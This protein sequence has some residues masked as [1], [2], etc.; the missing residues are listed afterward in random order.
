M[1]T[2]N[3]IV[4]QNAGAKAA[5]VFTHGFT[6]EMLETWQGFPELLTQDTELSGYNFYFWGYPTA[7][8]LHYALRGCPKTNV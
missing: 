1:M 4:Y 6:G 7:L 5:I 8:K 2:T 3:P